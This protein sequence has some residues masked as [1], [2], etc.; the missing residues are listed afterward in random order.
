MKP[1]CFACILSGDR[2]TRQPVKADI[3]III[4]SPDSGEQ[5]RNTLGGAKNSVLLDNLEGYGISNYTI[6]HSLLCNVH[7]EQKK[8]IGRAFSA[9]KGRLLSEIALVQPKKI[10]FLG[11][12][13][14]KEYLGT[15]IPASGGKYMTFQG[16]PTLCTYSMDEVFNVPDYYRDFSNTIGKL[17]QDPL[18]YPFKDKYTLENYYVDPNKKV[19]SLDIE[20]WGTNPARGMIHSIGFNT[21]NDTV[22]IIPKELVLNLEY[23]KNLFVGYIDSGYTFMAYNAEFEYSWFKYVY[24]IELPISDDPLYKHYAIDERGG[25]GTDSVP[26]KNVHRLKTVISKGYDVDDWS[27]DL[28]NVYLL[29]DKV[30]YDYLCKDVEANWLANDLCDRLIKEDYDKEPYFY[31]NIM[32]PGIPLLDKLNNNKVYIDLEYLNKIRGDVGNEVTKLKNKLIA[33]S[34]VEDFNPNSPIQVSRYLFRDRGFKQVKGNSVSEEVYTTLLQKVPDDVFLLTYKEYKEIQKLYSTYIEGFYKRLDGEDFLTPTFS[35]TTTDTGRLSSFDFNW[36]NI[37]RGKLVKRMFKAPEGFVVAQFDY[38]QLE[39]RISVEESGDDT[40]IAFV[41]EGRDI[42]R[43]VASIIF[44]VPVVDVTDD[45][46]SLAKARVFGQQ[47]L[48]SPKGIAEK[49]NISVEEAERWNKIVN[50]MIPGMQITIKSILK[51]LD[52]NQYVESRTGRRKRFPFILNR[53]RVRSMRQAVNS[54]IQ[55]LGSDINWGQLIEIN[56]LD[57]TDII[58]L[59]PVHDSGVFY[60]RKDTLDETVPLIQNIMENSPLATT[61]KYEVDVSIGPNL[62]DLEPYERTS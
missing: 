44:G 32:L 61:M 3:L 41:T 7:K 18:P 27:I 38:K 39:F 59:G 16:I 53:N 35:Q 62:G 50:T 47:Y 30:V 31:R 10:L 17:L 15:S 48:E 40:S 23:V 36:Q 11:S 22:N 21:K 28:S 51:S 34:G 45:Q 57:R 19:I 25:T 55:G 37:P 56:K 26:I 58:Q 46:R 29:P 43:E 13:V 49:Y 6:T 5:Y 2:I 12:A 54:P 8:E 9:C 14:T 60:L 24:G 42:H 33:E 52:E 1:N 20:T 4:E